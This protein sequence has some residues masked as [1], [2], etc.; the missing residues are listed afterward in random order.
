MA[1]S[2]AAAASFRR[3]PENPDLDGRFAGNLFGICKGPVGLFLG[4]VDHGVLGV[5]RRKLGTFF[6]FF[7]CLWRLAV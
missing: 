1:P 5:V 4:L 6:F 2:A 7:R 3:F